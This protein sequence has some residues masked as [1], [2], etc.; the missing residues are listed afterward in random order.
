VSNFLDAECELEP[1]ART[2][3][4]ELSRKFSSWLK[5]EGLK[6]WS[7]RKLVSE[8]LRLG[9]RKSSIDP[10]HYFDGIRLKGNLP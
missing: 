6:Q 3:R 7:A 10:E 4:A 1:D 9:I 8:L 2:A 5:D